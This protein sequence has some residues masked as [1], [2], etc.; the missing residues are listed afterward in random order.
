MKAL[1]EYLAKTLVDKPDVVEVIHTPQ[2]G[3]HLLELKVAPDDV[4]K[5]IG[6]DGR[7]VNAL[8]TIVAAA[9]QQQGQKARLEVLDDRR[10]PSVPPAS[11]PVPAPQT[12][13]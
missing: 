4:G 3:G 6:R 8:R 9:A 10:G 1:V 5:I 11:T 12:P 7:T 2:D 13:Q